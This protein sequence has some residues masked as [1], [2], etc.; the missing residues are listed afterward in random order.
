MRRAEARSAQI[1]GPAGI[2]HVFQVSSYSGEPFPS[3]SACNLFSKDHWRV[4]LGDEAEKSG[5]EM[6]FV[7]MAFVLSSARK[8]LTRT[9][10][11]PDWA[12]VCPSCKSKRKAPSAD[13]GEEMALGIAFE[14]IRSD[15][16][17]GPFIDIARGNM[18]SGNQVA[19]PLSR[20]RINFVVIRSHQKIAD[21]ARRRRHWPM[22]SSG[23]HAA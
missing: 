1:G 13:A 5:P 23:R 18:P 6:S 15:I 7:L 8:R 2:S 10:A 4:A 22:L 14:I 19:Q 16:N 3:V 17:N 12:I 21:K 20:I 9:G 11:C